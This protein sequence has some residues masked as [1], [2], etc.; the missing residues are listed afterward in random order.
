MRLTLK[1]LSLIAL[2]PAA[3]TLTSLPV[4][5]APQAFVN[6][7]FRPIAAS[8]GRGAQSMPLILASDDDDSRSHRRHGEES[9]RRHSDDGEHRSRF[10]NWF[11]GDDDD[12]DD[13]ENGS[14]NNPAPAGTTQPP[15]NGLF[16]TGTPPRVRV[17]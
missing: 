15:Q 17:N 12:D 4:L 11:G 8:D 2:L 5:G 16:G 13:D 1:T 9:R 6:D 14:A 3:A 7:S 10:W